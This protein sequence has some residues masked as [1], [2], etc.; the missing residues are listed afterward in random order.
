MSHA[1]SR[2]E[3]AVAVSWPTPQGPC[4]LSFDRAFCVGCDSRG[5]LQA[6]DE[7]VGRA[8]A[9]VF[10]RGGQW[11]VRDLDGSGGLLLDGE[12]I[13]SAPLPRLGI[14]GLA[15]GS[16][17]VMIETAGDS[18]RAAE[19]RS[20]PQARPDQ[21]A[22]TV[23]HGSQSRPTLRADPASTLPIRISVAGSEARE[24]TE[25]VRVGRDASCTIRIDDEGV[26]RIHAEFFRA[27]VIWY[28]RDLG[29]SNGTCLD[30]ETVTESPLPAQCSVAL[31]ANGPRLQLSYNAPGDNAPKSLEEFAAHY[32]DGRSQAPAG[33]RTMMVRRAFSSVQ[34]RQKRRYGSVIAGVG[35][36]LLV[37]IGVGIYQYVQL[38]RTRALAEQIFY[39]MKTI[40]L[41]LARLELQAEQNADS[42][43]IVEAERGRQQLAQMSSQ[44]D[45]LL[46]ELGVI[47]DRLPEEDRLILHMARVF[48]ECEVAMPEGF[49]GEVKRY[50]GIWRSNKRLSDA[51]SK[52]QGRNLGP[53]IARI[54]EAHRMPPQFFY[55]ALQESDFNHDAVG[56][57]TRFGIAKGLWQFMPETA[58]H[59]G[60]RTGPLRD[61][62]S[63][64]PDDQRFDPAAATD[65]A[66]RYLRDLYSGEAQASGLLV[67]AS[68]NWGTTRV[69]NRIRAMKENPRDRNF[70]ALLAQTD[71]PKETRDYVFLIFA[72]AVIGENP[73]LFGFEFDDPLKGAASKPAAT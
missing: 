33:D 22:R 29:S 51:L 63:Y 41:Q 43:R 3:T 68:Y 8:L 59:Y 66:A 39:N 24:F 54:M 60:L 4:R 56:P 14:L 69:R 53:E 23:L 5:M 34:R 45:A 12:R 16:L 27:G 55:V 11:W 2:N 46:K 1:D 7:D 19:S 13:Q 50:I 67:L 15:G 6:H 47:N 28:V 48:G 65:A 17:E 52:A 57:A 40:E 25:S 26:S 36:L 71:V 38:Q 18:P 64:D 9:A 30:G 44:Y 31:G 70:W 61:Q 72:A 49:V 32:L 20:D 37:A 10:R 42:T 58:A 35:A 21:D 62:R 73:G